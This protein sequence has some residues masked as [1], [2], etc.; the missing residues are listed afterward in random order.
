MA[1][2]KK[3]EFFTAGCPRSQITEKNLRKA[4][5]E[6]GLEIE[7]ESIDDPKEHEKRG[8]SAFPTIKIDG[9]VKSEGVFRDVEYFKELLNEYLK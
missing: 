8:I 4:L 9:E 6:M 5:K 7:I 3:I 2:P 1:I